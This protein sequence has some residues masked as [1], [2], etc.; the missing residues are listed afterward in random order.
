MLTMAESDAGSASL[1]PV[2]SNPARPAFSARLPTLLTALL[3]VW[4]IGALWQ[5]NRLIRGWLAVL[6]FRRGCHPVACDG[7]AEHPRTLCQAYAIRREP[8]LLEHGGG[9]S[10]MLLGIFRPAIIV[11]TGLLGAW[12][13]LNAGWCSNTNWHTSNAAT[14]RGAWP[15]PSCA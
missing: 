12:V 14:W 4:L 11:P 5:G 15:W 7:L 9:G 13:W 6:R 1:G 2:L 10:P 3:A 8:L